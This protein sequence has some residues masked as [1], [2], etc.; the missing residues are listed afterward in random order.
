[1]NSGNI[2]T[3]GSVYGGGN[4]LAGSGV[5]TY[6]LVPASSQIITTATG[7]SN[8]TLEG[9]INLG[10]SGVHPVGP[11]FAVTEQTI[12]V[13]FTQHENG[14]RVKAT[15]NPDTNLSTLELLRLNVLLAADTRATHPLSYI[16]S[17]SLERHF[18]FEVVQ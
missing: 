7:N 2:P 4:T 5:T 8:F 15:L 9:W 14:V 6:T 11:S 10:A 12:A 18:T 3:P 16:R 13:S 1:M 17:H